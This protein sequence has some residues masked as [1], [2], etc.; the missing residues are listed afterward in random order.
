MI[1]YTE[2]EIHMRGNVQIILDFSNYAT[3]KE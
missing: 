1:Y 2:P 3:K